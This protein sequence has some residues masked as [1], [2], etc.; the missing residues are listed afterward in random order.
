[1]EG[2]AKR[3]HK[4]IIR[5]LNFLKAMETLTLESFN[6]RTLGQTKTDPIALGMILCYLNLE[7]NEKDGAL[8]K[9][10]R[11][12]LILK[13]AFLKLVNMITD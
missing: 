12:A 3:E 8:G 5:Q 1:M 11:L 4:P 2:N 7:K 9:Q 13:R 10:K 6:F